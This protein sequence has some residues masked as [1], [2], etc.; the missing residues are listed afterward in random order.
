MLRRR[1]FALAAVALIVTAYLL[2][3]PKLAVIFA[4]CALLLVD[5][6]RPTIHT[7][8]QMDRELGLR[9][10]VSIPHFASPAEKLRADRSYR[11]IRVASITALLVFFADWLLPFL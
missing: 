2:H 11:F 3:G 8:E 5:R 4:A 6:N 10:V 9:P 7:G 1:R